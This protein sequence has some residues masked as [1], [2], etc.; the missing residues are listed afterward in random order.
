MSESLIQIF[1]TVNIG[2]VTLDQELRVQYWNRWMELHSGIRAEKII[3]SSLFDFFPNLNNIRFTKNCK[4]VLSFGNFSF[5]SQ[6]LHKYLF[7][8]R[9]DSSFGCNF[10]FMQQSCTMGP[11][12]D[13]NN[14]IISLFII[15][16]DVTELAASEQRLIELNTKDAL[17]GI[18]NRRY[19]DAHLGGECDR[20]LRYG[21]KM[22]LIMFDIDYFKK[23]NDNYGHQCGDFVLKAITTEIAH[24]SR[25]TDYFVRYGGEEFCCILPE[26]PSEEAMMLAER[27]RC[28]VAQ[29]NMAYQDKNVQVTISL[30]VAELRNE[31]T[32]EQLLQRADDALY[33]AKNKGRDRVVLK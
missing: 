29:L 14:S 27:F 25:R 3:G 22:T 4:V 28:H 10:E 30:G 19:L 11:L 12:R 32:P 31:D 9:P 1:D 23:V 2:V 16:Q 6:K 21:R 5:F 33:E 15:I 18:Y 13:Q 8:F 7:P 20:H 17:T 26:T 24:L